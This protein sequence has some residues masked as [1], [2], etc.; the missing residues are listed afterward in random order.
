MSLSQLIPLAIQGSVMLLVFGKGL[1][2]RYQD[3]TYLFRHPAQFARSMISMYGVMLG[4]ALCTGRYRL[5]PDRRNHR[6]A[7]VCAVA[8]ALARR[9]IGQRSLNFYRFVRNPALALGPIF[10]RDAVR[11]PH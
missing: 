7:A 8:Y 1:S 5:A 3:A 2:A 6:R 11:N 9:T 10:Y 4:F